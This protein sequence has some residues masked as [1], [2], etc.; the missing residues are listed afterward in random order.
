MSTVYKLPLLF[1]EQPEGG[2]T[3]TCPLIPEF[4]TEGDTIQE[5]IANVGDALTAVIELYED[6]GRPLP[7]VLQPLSNQERFLA[8]AVVAVA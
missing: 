7:A 1:E 2:Y 3:V 4:V 6:Q 8:E 5:A